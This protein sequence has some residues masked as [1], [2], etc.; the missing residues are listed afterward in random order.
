V[1]WW[2]A[3]G[4]GGA[5]AGALERAHVRMRAGQAAAS[6]RAAMQQRSVFMSA[7]VMNTIDGAPGGAPADCSARVVVRGVRI[8]CL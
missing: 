5:A 6:Q 3:G 8:R 1:V 7:I 2:R 4:G